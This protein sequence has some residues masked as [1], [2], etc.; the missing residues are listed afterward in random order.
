MAMERGQPAY[1]GGVQRNAIAT[2]TINPTMTIAATA[3]AVIL[4]FSLE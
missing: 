4:A 2:T 3:P 1:G